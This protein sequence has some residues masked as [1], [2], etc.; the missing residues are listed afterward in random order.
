MLSETG[1]RPPRRK[2]AFSSSFTSGVEPANTGSSEALNA[3]RLLDDGAA[4]EEPQE[5]WPQKQ[6]HR[7][8][9]AEEALT[10]SADGG[11]VS[12]D[13][14]C[15]GLDTDD[16]KHSV[17]E[18]SRQVRLEPPPPKDLPPGNDRARLSLEELR[19]LYEEE[20]VA[21]R[22]EDERRPLEELKRQ[23]LARAAARED[24][25]SATAQVPEH[26]PLIIELSESEV[27]AGA[28][29]MPPFLG[30]LYKDA[31]GDIAHAFLVAKPGPHWLDVTAGLQ[32]YEACP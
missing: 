19:R 21:K 16:A 12:L 5:F 24:A 30:P 2:G 27:K 31:D 15:R 7:D 13:E 32:R 25:P 3:T 11:F 17:K 14:L 23:H 29:A 6:Q 1:S 22:R 8:H 4:K 20:M 10:G 26:S 9:E 28:G 18:T